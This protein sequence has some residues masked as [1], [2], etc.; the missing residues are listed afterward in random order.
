MSAATTSTT[1]VPAVAPIERPSTVI[2][3][4][5]ATQRAA[6]QRAAAEGRLE[7]VTDYPFAELMPRSSL[8][9]VLGGALAF[10]T[11][12]LAVP[13]T[14]STYLARVH[15]ATFQLTGFTFF[16]LIAV[17]VLSGYGVTLA[18]EWLHATTCRLMGGNPTMAQPEQYRFVWS[19]K[20]QGFTRRSYAVVLVAPFVSVTVLWLIVL[21]AFPNVAALLIAALTVNMMLSVADLWPL[22]VALRQPPQATI[23]AD[24]HPG[25]VAYAITAPKVAPKMATK[26]TVTVPN[27]KQG[28]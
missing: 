20:G 16:L 19:A 23:F 28:R 8:V 10:L 24:R 2:D 15:H 26:K 13:W 3:A 9:S 4:F 25:F 1:A 27:K 5:D 14:V 18:H 7:E 12:M 11:F 17:N 22:V 6:S 21:A